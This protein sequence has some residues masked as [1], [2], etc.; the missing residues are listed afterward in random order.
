LLPNPFATF[1]EIPKN[2]LPVT[3]LRRCTNLPNSVTPMTIEKANILYKFD[4]RL[5]NA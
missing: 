4:D 5:N 1:P 2:F 3:A